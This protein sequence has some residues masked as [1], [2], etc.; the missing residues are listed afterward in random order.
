[1]ARKN[2]KSMS[3]KGNPLGYGQPL[4]HSPLGVFGSKPGMNLGI[5]NASDESYHTIS[6]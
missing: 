2:L 6:K 5:S 3:L 1:M 4:G